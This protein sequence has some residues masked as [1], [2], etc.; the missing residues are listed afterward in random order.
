[1][2]NEPAKFL[3]G[4]TRWPRA[5][6]KLWSSLRCRLS[7]PIL[8]IERSVGRQ[9]GTN[10]AKYFGSVPN[11]RNWEN[12]HLP[13]VLILLGKSA[14][15]SVTNVFAPPC[16]EL[17]SCLYRPGM[18]QI[19]RSFGVNLLFWILV[20]LCVAHH[21]YNV[22]NAVSSRPRWCMMKTGYCAV[23]RL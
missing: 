7:L 21:V 2:E 19:D 10:Q 11:G 15:P 13:N 1:M 20:P 18:L 17:W 4:K 12:V 22:S 6:P 9:A 23:S 8:D 3:R 5:K 14:F 16:M